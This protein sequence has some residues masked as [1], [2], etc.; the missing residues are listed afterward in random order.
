MLHAMTLLDD[1]LLHQANGARRRGSRNSLMRMKNTQAAYIE[2]AF[3]RSVYLIME[4]PSSSRL[5]FVVN[6]TTAVLIS[7]NSLF[8]CL[9]T[10]PAVQLEIDFFW[11]YLQLSM[12]GLFT[13]EF[14]LRFIAHTYSWSAM[15]S[16]F[17]NPLNLIDFC[18]FMPLYIELWAKGTPKFGIQRISI[19]R[20]FRLFRLFKV[21]KYQSM[22]QV[23]LHG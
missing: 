21:Y 14:I 19:L 7:L 5:A 10:L 8:M 15:R 4:D 23:S 12:I 18:A 1:E 22:I 11:F 9:E 17:T 20:L 13:V 16:F 3:I 6:I 2:N